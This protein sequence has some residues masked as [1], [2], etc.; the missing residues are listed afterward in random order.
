MFVLK[1]DQTVTWPAEIPVPTNG[2]TVNKVRVNVQYLLLDMDRYNEVKHSDIELLN[3]VVVGWD[4]DA[5]GTESTDSGN[6]KKKPTALEFNKENLTKL[7]K[8]G[9]VR[10]G[11]I[12]G[13]WQAQAGLEKNS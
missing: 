8:I 13:Y 5:F 3:T 10:T 6:S 1:E 4:K 9:Y 11:L 7:I 2:G 12:Q